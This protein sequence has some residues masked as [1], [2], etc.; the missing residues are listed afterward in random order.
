[1]RRAISDFLFVL[2][3]RMRARLIAIVACLLF[4]SIA[5]SIAPIF[6]ADLIDGGHS[7]F[8]TE[9]LGT[10]V[11]LY[12]AARF[13]GQLLIDFR[14]VVINPFLYQLSYDLATLVAERIG[15]R[16]RRS[17]RA[18]ENIE[19]VT[20]RV[21]IISKMQIGSMEVA[22]SV[23]SSLL[24]A[25]CDLVIVVIVVS[26]VAGA[27]FPYLFSAGIAVM[28]LAISLLRRTE[29]KRVAL[30]NDADNDVIAQYGGLISNAKIICEYDALP[31]FRARLQQV[32]KVSMEAHRAL[33]RI[34]TARSIVI[35]LVT[36]AAYLV[37][38]YIASRRLTDGQLT[39]GEVFLLA[40]Y[41]DR[42]IQ[43]IGS[44]SGSAN[45]F[46]TGLVSM[47]A[48]YDAVDELSAEHEQ[49]RATDGGHLLPVPFRGDR[50][51][52]A[53]DADPRIARGDRVHVAGKSGSGKSMF[54]SELYAE[55]RSAFNE[56][57]LYLPAS[58][59][60]VDGTVRDNIRFA[61]N[62]ISDANIAPHLEIWSRICG[63]RRIAIDEDASSLSLGE[64]Q[65]IA[66]VRAVL[67]RPNT[68]MLD[69]A[70]NSIDAASETAV[71]RYVLDELVGTTMFV[72]S[73]R[74]LV[75]MEPD[76]VVEFGE[77]PAAGCAYRPWTGSHTPVSA[78]LR[79]LR[80]STHR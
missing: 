2:D 25:V 17:V 29:L 61:S 10:L 56:S 41:L 64:R 30:A 22:Y 43:P 49:Q 62:N 27:A 38:L 72:V 58:P 4:S 69:E 60:I 46:Q 67:N 71:L 48:G 5:I 6:L 53:G 63:N 26:A 74:P 68:L 47:G 70:L 20:R 31:Y 3:R 14:W 54:L 24:P 73:H 80:G 36:A 78:T 8:G 35:T 39:A 79:V 18:S 59:E 57:V 42:L 1:M 13:I 21:S 44:I 9:S 50:V 28:L 40:T 37:V 77:V 75:G 11:L 15:Q 32:V 23:L 52:W 12:V 76:V 55:I 34:K 16:S 51:A 45:S 65:F 33:F 66:V 19:A 7:I